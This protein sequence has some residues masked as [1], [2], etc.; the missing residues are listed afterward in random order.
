MS[1]R[2]GR[3]NRTLPIRALFFDV[4]GVLT[5]GRIYLSDDGNDFPAAPLTW[6]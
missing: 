4:D 2:S 5:D 6:S 3:A 1:S